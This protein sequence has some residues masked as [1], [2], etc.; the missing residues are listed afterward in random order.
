MRT[1]PSRF[2][3]FVTPTERDFEGAPTLA[4]GAAAGKAV[5]VRS[6]LERS[7]LERH[8][9]AVVRVI[10]HLWGQPELNQYFAKI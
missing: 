6:E 10:T 5:D 1:T 3:T 9:P 7:V 2:S 4:P 8:Y